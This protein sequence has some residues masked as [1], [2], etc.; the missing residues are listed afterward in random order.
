MK[1]KWE[2]SEVMKVYLGQLLEP[3]TKKTYCD[4]TKSKLPGQNKKIR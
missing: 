4:W 1:R 3:W 2:K